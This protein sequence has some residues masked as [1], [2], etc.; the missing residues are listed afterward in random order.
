MEP[1]DIRTSIAPEVFT[2]YDSQDAEDA[3]RALDILKRSMAE[4]PPPDVVADE[5]LRIVQVAHPLAA[6]PVWGRGPLLAFA[7]RLFPDAFIEKLIRSHY[8]MRRGSKGAARRASP[9]SSARTD[10]DAKRR[11]S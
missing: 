8:G 4:A 3:R 9:G 1:K 10:R 2:Q 7:N 5:V 11:R 6:Y